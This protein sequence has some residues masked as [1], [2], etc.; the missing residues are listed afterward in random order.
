MITYR[1]KAT[2]ISKKS[3]ATLRNAARLASGYYNTL[4]EAALLHFETSGEVLAAN[5]LKALCP[6]PKELPTYHSEPVVERV[7]SVMKRYQK[8]ESGRPRKKNLKRGRWSLEITVFKQVSNKVLISCGVEAQTYKVSIPGT[9]VS[10][11]LRSDKR[12]LQG[13]P[14][15]LSVV[16]DNCGDVWVNI[17]TDVEIPF[18]VDKAIVEELGVDLGIRE[19]AVCAGK[20]VD[21]NLVKF[22]HERSLDD[23]YREMEKL[24]NTQRNKDWRGTKHAHRR[25]ER[26]RKHSNHNLACQIVRSSERIYFGDVSSKFLFV[27][28]SSKIAR[29]AA[30]ACHAQLKTFTGQKA[31]RAT[32][33]RKVF[34]VREAY[35][36]KTCG[37]CGN[38]NNIGSLKFWTCHNCRTYHD[39]DVN[40]ALNMKNCRIREDLAK[41]WTKQKER[42]DFMRKIR[43]QPRKKES[44]LLRRAKTPVGILQNV[45]TSKREVASTA[46]FASSLIY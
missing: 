30:D 15:R 41:V 23:I 20:D 35:T 37:F 9:N 11:N 10:L 8:G 5:P 29:K 12:I 38:Q 22:Q 1:G 6:K 45:C 18:E 44:L 7:V 46:E 2:K 39:R 34:L 24:E 13:E 14:K 40:A 16:C 32:S 31:A 42:Y 33:E 36:S 28:R 3:T 4:L 19:Y 21:G 43:Q 26:K 25:I 27:N 17:T